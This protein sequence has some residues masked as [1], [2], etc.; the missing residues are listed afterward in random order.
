MICSLYAPVYTRRVCSIYITSIKAV[1]GWRIVCQYSGN[2]TVGVFI[3]MWVTERPL[4]ECSNKSGF[5]SKCFEVI[6]TNSAL[7]SMCAVCVAVFT[8]CNT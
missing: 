3:R 1:L 6:K 4:T 8:H 2:V 5:P 7:Y